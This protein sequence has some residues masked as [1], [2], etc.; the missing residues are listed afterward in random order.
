M[1]SSL[2]MLVQNLYRIDLAPRA[3]EEFLRNR[4]NLSAVAGVDSAQ[5][6]GA[7]GVG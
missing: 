4:G 3:E 1:V 7:A 6:E 2:P 5:Q